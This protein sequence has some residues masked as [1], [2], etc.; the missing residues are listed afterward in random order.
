MK[1]LFLTIFTLFFAISPLFCT[2]P[3]PWKGDEYAK[4]SQSQKSSAEDFIQGIEFKGT[5][6]ILDVGCGDGKITAAM[7]KAVPQGSVTGVDISPSMV[8]TAKN[9]FVNRNNLNF[10]VQDAAKLNFDKKFDVVTSFTVMQWVLEQAQALQCFEK[11]LK[12]GGKLWIQMPTGL[13]TAMKQALEKTISSD[14]WKNYFTQFSAPW[15]FYGAE[16]YRTLL[17]NA[18]FTPTRL[19]VVTKHEHFPSRAVFQ[20]F[21]KQWFPYLRPIPAELKD[22]FLTELLDHYL[23]IL[24]VDE[25]GRVSF[26]VDR[27]EVEATK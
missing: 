19:D 11:A 20:N 4:N 17:M 9:A 12:P 14:R 23:K 16:E 15:R 6:A 3:D 25:Q 1:T 13:P 2:R 22:A 5:E 10:L 27:L 8:Q 7:A 26:I 24:P 21:L 18:H